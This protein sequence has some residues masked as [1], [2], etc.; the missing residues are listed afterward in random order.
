MG[1]NWAKKALLEMIPPRIC[2]TFRRA[3]FWFRPKNS[4]IEILDR[5]AGNA[6]NAMSGSHDSCFQ[7]REHDENRFKMYPYSISRAENQVF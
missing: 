2:V 7:K 6:K 1:T 5:Q 4:K 3:P